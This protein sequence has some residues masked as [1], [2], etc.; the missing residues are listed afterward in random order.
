MCPPHTGRRRGL[1]NVLITFLRDKCFTTLSVR[2]PGPRY[3]LFTHISWI[4]YTPEYITSHVHTKM[5][6]V[7]C[8]VCVDYPGKI[9]VVRKIVRWVHCGRSK[10]CISVFVYT[11]SSCNINSSLSTVLH[12][13]KR[14]EALRVG[15]EPRGIPTSIAG[16]GPR[17]RSE[18]KYHILNVW[19][20]LIIVVVHQLRE[21][22]GFDIADCPTTYSTMAFGS[23]F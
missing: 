6:R 12:I 14:L 19:P 21:R 22:W 13:A 17:H 15:F 8:E 18:C 11:L 4:V 16:W 2:T 5:I 10:P 23:L 3:E 7:I 1:T 9:P 20:I